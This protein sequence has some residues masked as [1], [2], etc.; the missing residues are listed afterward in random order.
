MITAHHS[1]HSSRFLSPEGLHHLEH[2]HH[3]LCLA[4]LNDGGYGTEHATATHH[5]TAGKTSPHSHTH[6]MVTASLPAVYHNGLVACF[7]LDSS[8]LLYHISHSTQVRAATV[9]GPVGDVEL[10]NLMGTARL[11][12]RNK[13]YVHHHAEYLHITCEVQLTFE[14]STLTVLIT[15]PFSLFSLRSSTSNSPNIWDPVL[16]QYW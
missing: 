8:H 12:V 10:D 7:H 6:D 16:G 11:W 14:F 1:A 3:S 15:K 4:L 2:I 5:V 9:K 13:E